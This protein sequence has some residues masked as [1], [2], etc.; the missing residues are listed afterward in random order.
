MLAPITITQSITTT[1]LVVLHT[2]VVPAQQQFKFLHHVYAVEGNLAESMSTSRPRSG[3]SDGYG[4]AVGSKIRFYRDD[5]NDFGRYH[6]GNLIIRAGSRE[7]RCAIDIDSN[8][9]P[10]GHKWS[11]FSLADNDFPVIRSLSSG[12]HSLNSAGDSGALDYIRSPELV[13]RISWSTGDSIRAIE[14]LEAFVEDGRRY[15]VFGEPFRTGYGVHN[16]HQNQ[17]SEIGGGHDAEN[18]FGRMVQY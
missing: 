8:G 10:N 13:S 9:L 3:L 1:C 4:V 15:F 17:G 6:H 2:T 11:T 18:A 14:A 12:W 7:Y 5:P 16:V